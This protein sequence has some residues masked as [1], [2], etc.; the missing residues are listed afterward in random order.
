[1]ANYEIDELNWST[2]GMRLRHEVCGD[3]VNWPWEAM[4]HRCEVIW[5]DWK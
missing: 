4:R 5:Q 2:S 1:M 3:S